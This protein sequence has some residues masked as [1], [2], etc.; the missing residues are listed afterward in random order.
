[1]IRIRSMAPREKIGARRAEADD[2]WRN[3]TSPMIHFA[4]EPVGGMKLDSR[5]GADLIR[6][7]LDVAAVFPDA[8]P[9]KEA[10]R[11]RA[12]IIARAG[13]RSA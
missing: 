5:R 8:R 10:L 9:A 7:D 2:C 3:T 6:L 11:A 1:M 12:E 13:R 4:R